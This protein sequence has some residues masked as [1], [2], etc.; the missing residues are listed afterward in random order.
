LLSSE[1][2]TTIQVMKARTVEKRIFR[3]VIMALR[4]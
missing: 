2:L 3:N 1:V 4:V